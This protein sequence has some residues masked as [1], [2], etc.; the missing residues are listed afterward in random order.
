MI[1]CQITSKN[2]SDAYAI[3]LSTGDFQE[4]TLKQD[5]NIRPNRLFTADEGIIMYKAGSVRRSKLEPAIKKTVEIL[6]E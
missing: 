1:L 5:S 2:V 4:G 6:T 3:P